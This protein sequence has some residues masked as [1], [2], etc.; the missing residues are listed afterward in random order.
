MTKNRLKQERRNLL[1]RALLLIVIVLLIQ[2]VGRL[3]ASDR[4]ELRV[5]MGMGNR[6]GG[7]GQSGA[8]IEWET[9]EM[10]VR[11]FDVRDDG[12]IQM[13]FSPEE[14]GN[15]E[16][17]VKDSEG[18]YLYWDHLTVDRFGTVRSELTGNFTGDSAAVLAVTVLMLG[19]GVLLLVQFVRLRGPL[20]Y[21][22]DAMFCCGFG[23]FASVSGLNLLSLFLQRILRPDRYWMRDVYETLSMSPGVFMMLT[24]PLVLIFSV[25]LM[26]SNAE[27]LRHERFRVRNVLG[28]GIGL[29][30]ILSDA[31]AIWVQARN[32]MGSVEELRI[33]NATGSVVATI[34]TYFECILMSSVICGLRAAKHIP[35]L[36]KDYIL[37][38]GCGFRKDGTLPPLLRGRVDK[39]I[40]FREKQIRETGKEAVL[41]PS[42]G[43]GGSEPMAEAEAMARYLKEQG[44]PDQA[45]LKEDQSRNTFQN[46]DFSRQKIVERDGDADGN[47]VIYVTTNYHVFRSG[48]WAGLAGLEAEGLG[49]RTKWWFWP[50]AFMRE[51]IGLLA[52][53]IPQEIVLLVSLAVFFGFIATQIV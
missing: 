13:A 31:L 25:L 12:R 5:D 32:F 3:A 40:E 23:I 24:S 36:N 4:F 34:F 7:A 50:N 20:L 6:P 38:L 29:G 26:I 42:G 22:Y 44:V 48:V 45:V 18:E 37:I 11:Q 47:R 49:S 19:L 17:S 35:A 14:P 10:P 33:F 30:M 43:Q 51:C 41:V 46:M 15:Y 9:G 8:R 28:F 27:L 52:N 2:A 1:R 39:A 16:F 53:R 21:S